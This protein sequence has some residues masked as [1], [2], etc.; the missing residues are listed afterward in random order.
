MS[1]TVTPAEILE[2]AIR[3]EQNAR[4]YYTRAQDVVTMPGAKE[5]LAELAAEEVDHEARFEAIRTQEDYSALASGTPPPDLRL[6]DYLV[7]E[8][9][10]RDS[11]PQDILITAIKM[12]QA[13]VDLYS[14][15][16]DLYRGTGIEPI[17]SGLIR[18]EQGHKARLEALY[19]DVF[20]Q[21]W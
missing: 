2:A 17:L 9:L 14:R 5:L 18:E 10:G 6:A 20:L 21:D 8:P 7:V 19:H 13:A 15:W 3:M 1:K 16:R 11:T 4:E 12:E